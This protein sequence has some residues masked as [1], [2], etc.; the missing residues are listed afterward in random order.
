MIFI[1]DLV[2]SV[3]ENLGN[4]G[5]ALTEEVLITALCYIIELYIVFR[6]Y[7]VG[8]LKKLHKNQTI[9]VMKSN[10]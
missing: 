3:V 8:L 2:I 4:S 10:I 7:L 5:I 6:R 9:L 1:S